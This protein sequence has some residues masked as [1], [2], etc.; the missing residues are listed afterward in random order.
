[1]DENLPIQP[2]VS[3]PIYKT[4]SMIKYSKYKHFY[5]ELV[6]NILIY[7][8]NK[9]HSY[10]VK[11]KEVISKSKYTKYSVFEEQSHSYFE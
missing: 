7:R 9:I 1:M 6:W 4:F 3:F 8:I 11:H 2:P 10:Y 5:S